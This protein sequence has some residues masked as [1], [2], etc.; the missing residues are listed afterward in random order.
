MLV[1]MSILA[2]L[3]LTADSI[4]HWFDLPAA[5]R[6]MAMEYLR[7]YGWAIVPN[8]VIIIAGA[9]FRAVGKPL[10]GFQI[11]ALVA[12][13]NMAGNFLLVFGMGP[14]TGM[15]YTGIAW[16][17]VLAM[18]VGASAVLVVLC[19]RDW[20]GF[21][22]HP[23]TTVRKDLVRLTKISWPAAI[24]Q[25]AW[26]A[27]NLALYLILGKLQEESV[28]AMAAYTNGLRLESI[29]Y[30]P[31]FALNMAAAVLVGQRL[32]GGDK[33]QAL[34]VGWRTAKWGAAAISIIAV[35]LFVGAPHL[36]HML[37]SNEAVI[38]ETVRYLRINLLV[39]P[40]MVVCMVLG[41]SMQGAGDTRGV[42]MIIVVA[43]WMVRIPL[44]FILSLTLQ[45]NAMGVWI[46]MDISM[47]VQSVWMIRRYFKGHWCGRSPT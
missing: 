26:N 32:G 42:M 43:I 33:K 40:I 27:G 39:A 3:F 30:L 7:I 46:A 5:I 38:L 23:S 29:T 20:R 19:G 47:L 10:L 24:L 21:W 15:G 22:T 2:L 6:S 35:G 4:V 44:A 36:A 8:Y 31:A 37:S 34:E 41:G 9:S 16:A 14:F 11:M 18:A 17:T 13:L 45:L 1:G 12:A 25:F 28:A